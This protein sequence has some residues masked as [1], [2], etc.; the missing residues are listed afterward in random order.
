MAAAHRYIRSLADVSD[1]AEAIR[2]LTTAED[3]LE[4]GRKGLRTALGA[5]IRGGVPETE[6]EVIVG[7]AQA[8]LVLL[9][10]RVSH[11]RAASE[12]VPPDPEWAELMSRAVVSLASKLNDASTD[13]SAFGSVISALGVKV[14]AREFANRPSLEVTATITRVALQDLLGDLGDVAQTWSASSPAAPLRF[15]SSSGPC[16]TAR[17]LGRGSPLS[18][19]RRPRPLPDGTDPDRRHHH[20]KGEPDTGSTLRLECCHLIT[21]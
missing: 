17:R 20:R 4:K 19:P 16:R 2:E 21:W 14:R 12:A 5:A 3:T 7:A 6:V 8:E 1:R 13:P 18:R 9:E 11:L 15:G 10:R